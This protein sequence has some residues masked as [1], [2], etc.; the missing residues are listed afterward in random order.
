MAGSWQQ[1]L[2]FWLVGK[3]GALLTRLLICTI[4]VQGPPPKSRPPLPGSHRNGIYAMWHHSLLLC[5]YRYRGQG[6]RVLI[7][8]HRDGEYIARIA[9][10]LGFTTTRGSTTRGGARALMELREKVHDGDDIA[11]TTDGPKGPRQ[12]VQKGAVFLAQVTGLPVVPAIVGLARYWEIP[13]WDRFRIPKPF[14]RAMLQF[15]DPIVVPRQVTDEG[16]EAF[17]QQLQDTMQAMQDAL[18]REMQG[19]TKRDED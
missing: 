11:F 18:D 9:H 19:T 2:V 10:G 1:S 4:R 14:S 6:I 13:S 3:L 15:G 5:V 12:I 17:R 7:S 8:Q 16:L